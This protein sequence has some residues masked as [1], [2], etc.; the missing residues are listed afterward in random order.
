MRGS[1]S[2]SDRSVHARARLSGTPLELQPLLAMMPAIDATERFLLRLFLRRCIT[3]CVR[4]REFAAM[5]GAAVLYR[6][7]CAS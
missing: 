4:R 1:T 5:N 3:W 7:V 2:S 6:A